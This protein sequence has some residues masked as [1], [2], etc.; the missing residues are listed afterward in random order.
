M[1]VIPGA[2][3]QLAAG[4]A[5][6]AIGIAFP[7]VMPLMRPLA[8]TLIGETILDLVMEL[9]Q[10][11]DTAHDAEAYKKSKAITDRNGSAQDIAGRRG[12]AGSGGGMAG[13]AARRATS[14]HQLTARRLD[15]RW[16][17]RHAGAGH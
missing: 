13:G 15:A 12:R 4:L 2:Q 1:Q 7:L 17:G 9:V 16:A 8:G 5:A 6:L 10:Q 14:A 11:S 3:V